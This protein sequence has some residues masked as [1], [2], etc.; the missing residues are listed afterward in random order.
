MVAMIA[1]AQMSVQFFSALHAQDASRVESMLVQDPSLAAAHDEQGNSAVGTALSAPRGEVF[2]PRAENR[3]LDALLARHPPLSLY[4]ECAVGKPAAVRAL[5][6]KDREFVRSR[7]KVGWTPLHHAA[8]GNN[9]AVAKVLL[10][11]GADVNAV[12]QNRFANTPLQ[13]SLLNRGNEVA[14]VLVAA[15]ADVNVR[16]SEGFVALHEAA[17]SGNDEAVRMLLAAGADRDAASPGGRTPLD[18]ALKNKHESTAN[19]LRAPR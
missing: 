8:F 1:A 12:A 4:E 19:L 7:S 14:R 17:V 10:E 6:R 3:A 16:M 5:L 15:G 2:I 18:E 11:A 13:V 9:V